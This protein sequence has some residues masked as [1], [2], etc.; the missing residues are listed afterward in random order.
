MPLT[1]RRSDYDVTNTVQTTDVE[2]VSHEVLNLFQSMYPLYPVA[3]LEQAFRDWQ[4]LFSGH[5]PGFLSCDTPYHDLQHTL[6]VT[7]AVTRLI[8]GFEKQHRSIGAFGSLL[9]IITGLFHDAGYVRGW[10]DTRHQNGA[11]LT[12]GHVSRS[13]IFLDR[14]LPAI[15]LNHGSSICRQL[16]HFTGYEVTFEN[17]SVDDRM[18]RSLG[19]MV[20]TADLLAQMSDR[21][22]LEKCRDR[23]YPEFV[24]AGMASADAP[25]GGYASAEDFMR[26][27]PGF[28]AMVQKRL[29]DSLQGVYQHMDVF[30]GDK[31]NLYQQSI[32]QNQAYLADLIQAGDMSKLRRNPP[33]TLPGKDFPIDLSLYGK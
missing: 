28:F 6:D 22:Y 27:T 32:A 21:C 13:A 16:V 10:Y 12:R 3:P 30:F 8:W 23:L 26:K 29:D 14:Y 19:K 9:G 33:W 2:S 7:L 17:I 11:E 31:P 1:L 4:R 5:F 15:G 18:L 24:A 25:N 20:G